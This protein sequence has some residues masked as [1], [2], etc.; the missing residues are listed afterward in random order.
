MV[1]TNDGDMIVTSYWQSLELLRVGLDRKSS[2]YEYSDI[3]GKQ[4]LCE[5]E[6]EVPMVPAWSLSCLWDI[7]HNI[8]KT[9]EFDTKMSALELKDVLVTTIIRRLKPQE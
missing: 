3:D 1:H 5:K 2:D 8:D 4:V 9:Y 7:V 6:S